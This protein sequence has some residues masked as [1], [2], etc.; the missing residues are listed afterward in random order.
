MTPTTAV[1]SWPTL[2]TIVGAILTIAI[3]ALTAAGVKLPVLSTERAAFFALVIIG[4]LM[5]MIGGSGRVIGGYGIG[6]PVTIIGSVI[7]IAVLILG[8]SILFGFR[9]PLVTDD[10]TALFFVAGLIIVKV[11]INGIFT[12]VS[13]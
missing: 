9:L 12:F 2:W 6:H 1:S 11:A 13:R 3:T 5:C 7:G 8:A 4:F 10:R